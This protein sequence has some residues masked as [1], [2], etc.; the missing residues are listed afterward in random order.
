M[1]VAN[2]AKLEQLRK[3]RAE[4]Y[5]YWQNRDMA[6]AIEEGQKACHEFD[7]QYDELAF[8]GGLKAGLEKIAAGDLKMLKIAVQ[9]L[10]LRPFYYRAQYNRMAITRILKRQKLPPELQVRFDTTLQKL[11]DWRAMHRRPGWT[12]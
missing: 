7:Q 1:I 2:A 6:K 11:R 3:R 4:V 10:E 9:V 12:L 8:P 5:Q